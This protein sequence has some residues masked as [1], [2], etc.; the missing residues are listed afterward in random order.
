VVISHYPTR[1]DAPHRAKWPVSL[2]IKLGVRAPARALEIPGESRPCSPAHRANRGVPPGLIMR[3]RQG[4]RGAREL[5][6]P[7]NSAYCGRSNTK[8]RS[9]TLEPASDAPDGPFTKFSE[10]QI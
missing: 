2:E 10:T 8:L 7:T 6:T 1:D 9:A 3:R 4:R 5:P